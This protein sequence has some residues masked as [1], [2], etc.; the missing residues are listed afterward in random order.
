VHGRGKRH[1][2][3]THIGNGLVESTGKAYTQVNV[4]S[5]GLDCRSG[6]AELDRWLVK[7]LVEDFD[8]MEKHQARV[9]KDK[10][11]V[12]EFRME[13]NLSVDD[14]RKLDGDSSGS[15]GARIIYHTNFRFRERPIHCVVDA[16][17]VPSLSR[18]RV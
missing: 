13:A 4:L 18:A 6:G 14:G 11:A 3:I 7:I 16:T 8:F 5:S 1:R 9:T 10:R 15:G 12:T 2:S 17:A